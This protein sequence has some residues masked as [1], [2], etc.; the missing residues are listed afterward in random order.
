MKIN[1]PKMI[2]VVLNTQKML[3]NLKEIE[4]KHDLQNLSAETDCY[5]NNI[6]GDNINSNI[7]LECDQSNDNINT[8]INTDTNDGIDIIN[9]NINGNNDF[10]GD[11]DPDI[12]NDSKTYLIQNKQL[13]SWGKY[14]YIDTFVKNYWDR[15]CVCDDVEDI[16]IEDDGDDSDDFIYDEY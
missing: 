5:D 9:C 4:K 8:L 3:L 16:I 1:L 6:Q 10:I 11:N 14:M 12:S 7:T 15:I 13:S 2:Q